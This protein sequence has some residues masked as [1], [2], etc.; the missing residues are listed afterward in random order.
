MSK[1]SNGSSMQDVCSIC[2]I[3][4]HASSD[5]LCI[6]RSNCATKH[7]NATQRFPPTNNPYSNTY[8]YGWRNYPNFFW[9][10]QNAPLA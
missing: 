9:R 1:V 4:I 7:V 2:D 8:N 5:C 10:S 3:F 6:G